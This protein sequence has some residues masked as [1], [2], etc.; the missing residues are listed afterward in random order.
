[1][2]KR[3]KKSKCQ[4]QNSVKIQKLPLFHA[5]YGFSGGD[6]MVYGDLLLFLVTP[7][8]ALFLASPFVQIPGN[9]TFWNLF[10]FLVHILIQYFVSINVRNI[11][12]FDRFSKNDLIDRA[13]SSRLHLFPAEPSSA[14]P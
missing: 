9:Q 1:M 10:Y 3:L 11:K 12:N 6:F 8:F 2:S 7:V 14:V 5:K 13:W 4:S